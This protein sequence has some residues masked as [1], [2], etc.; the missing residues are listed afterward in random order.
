MSKKG[1]K[2]KKEK[3]FKLHDASKKVEKKKK[4][5]SLEKINKKSKY[6]VLQEGS[7]FGIS[8]DIENDEVVKG[9]NQLAAS[10]SS[11]P[12]A[13][14]AEYSFQAWTQSD[15]LNTTPGS[16]PGIPMTNAELKRRRQRQQRFQSESDTQDDLDLISDLDAPLIGTSTVLEKPYFRLTSKPRACDV[17]P[18]AVLTEAL[19]HVKRLWRDGH[20]DYIRVGDLLQA[21]RQDLTVQHVRDALAVSVYET[22]GRIAI[23][24]GDW[25]ELRR[26]H[27]VLKGLYR[28]EKER[29]TEKGKGVK[30]ETKGH[31][32]E[33]EAYG[34]LLAQKEQ[35]TQYSIR[36]QQAGGTDAPLAA[37]LAPG[38]SSSLVSEMRQ[39]PI[40]VLGHPNV[41]HAL[42]VCSSFRL[43]N[44]IRFVE[45]YGA[46][47]AM[48]AYLMDALLLAARAAAAAGLKRACRPAPVPIAL[49]A[50]MMGFE[51]T[52]HCELYLD[53]L[54]MKC[55]GGFLVTTANKE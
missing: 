13:I 10:D 7:S 5:F 35:F 49:A 25:A 44:W 24:V 40:E 52:K 8:F 29:E 11:A 16:G 37:L 9:K 32:E 46:A 22:H 51:E 14:P 20:G 41:S 27:A 2:D 33:F 23:E 43:G 1:K 19:R 30:K 12:K 4:D 55:E 31:P 17:R 53:E 50:R 18:P 26:C 36:I 47:P 15:R 28:E 38:G 48:S 21:I 45:L 39:L 34:L 6:D 42:A 3:L 54:G